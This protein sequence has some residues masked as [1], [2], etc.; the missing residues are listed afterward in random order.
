M[1]N[2]E[3]PQPI[4]DHRAPEPAPVAESNSSSTTVE[5]DN[6]EQALESHEVIELQTFS[7]RKAW[8]EEKIKF[9]ESLPPIEVFAD[10]D[11]L[12][13]SA[14]EIPGLPTR[15]QLQQWIVE[16]DLIEK[17]SEIFDKGELK[18]LRQLT[19]AATQRNLSPEDTDLIELTLTTIYALDKL[20]HLLR[21]RSDNLDL[22][23]IRLDWEEQRS[24]S[25]IERRR[26]LE[27]LDMFMTTRARW[28]P[29]IYDATP[30]VEDSPTLSR[31][32]SVT[33]M[34]SVTSDSSSMNNP[35]FARSARFK[36]GEL[37]G[38]DA[39]Q[40]GARVT[41]LSHGRVAAAGRFL[42]KLIDHSRKPVPEVLLDEQDRLEE[43]SINQMENVNKFVLSL[44]MQ[45]R[46]AD[47]IYVETVK[48]QIAAK[49]LLE[50]IQAARY[51][52]PTSRQS[53]AFKSRVDTLVQRLSVRVNPSTKITTFPKP[54]HHLF[55]QQREANDALALYLTQEIAAAT[56]LSQQAE[57]AAK[58]Y[59]DSWEAVDRVE[60]LVSSANELTSSFSSV[61]QRL[62]DGVSAESE[63]GSP[64]DLMSND[65]LEP[66]RH[67]VFLALLPSIQ[68]EASETAIKAG[69]LVKQSQLA[70]YAL[71]DESIDPAFKSD[72]KAAIRQLVA[73][74]DQCQQLLDATSQRVARL[75]EARHVWAAMDANLKEMQYVR[76]DIVQQ[77]EHDCWKQEAS[78]N[79]A[80]LTPESPIVELSPVT[81]SA[82]NLE[83]D[84]R[85]IGKKL[86]DTVDT[87][88]QALSVT[89]EKPLNECLSTK[90]KSVRMF[91]DGL[92]RMNAMLKTIQEQ[93]A[94]MSSVRSE[95]NAFLLRIEDAKARLGSLTENVLGNDDSISDV[96]AEEVSTNL[97]L[98]GVQS[99]V[100]QFI[101]SLASRV[102]FVSKH[103]PLSPARATTFRRPSQGKTDTE[104]EDPLQRLPLDLGKLDA[105]VRAD[106][107]TYVMR[108]RGVLDSVAKTSRQLDVAHLAKKVDG[109][110]QD[111]STI[112][113]QAEDDHDALQASL[114]SLPDAQN[115]KEGNLLQHIDGLTERVEAALN[116][117]RPRLSRC[118]S[119]IRDMLRQMDASA[120]DFEPS[121]RQTLYS[122]RLR[123]K[124][125]STLATK[126]ALEAEEQRK[127]EEEARRIAE[128]VERKR[129]EE[130]ARVRDEAR[131]KEEQRLE[132]VRQA[133]EEE[134]RKREEEAERVR[135]EKEKVEE[136]ERKRKEKA[137][138]DEAA[139]AQREK[140]RMAQ[141][142]SEKARLM[143]ERRDIE[144]KL[145]R[146]ESLLQEERRLQA[147]REQLALERTRI[148]KGQIKEESKKLLLAEQEA[149][150]HLARADAERVKA[151]EE[152]KRRLQKELEFVKGEHRRAL[153][154]REDLARQHQKAQHRSKPSVVEDD[155]FGLSTPATSATDDE[156]HLQSVIFG[157]R[158]RLRSLNINE[159]ARPM[160][161]KKG[162]A[163]LPS[164]DQ[165][166]M[167]VKEASQLPDS[168]PNLTVDAELR[169]FRM[170]LE[171]S[172]QLI[173]DIDNLARLSEAI[174]KCD[175]A[176]SDLLEHIDSYPSV[177]LTV[178][179][180]HTSNMSSLPS[181]QLAA[182]TAFTRTV[183]DEMQAIFNTV[184]I[185][186]RAISERTRVHQTW[187]ELEEMAH[188][189]LGGRKS[190][191][192]SV[193]S[194]HLSS[195]RNSSASSSNL[196]STPGT[197]PGMSTKKRTSYSNLSVSSINV[198]GGKL[199]PPAPIGNR[200]AV[201]GESRRS[202]S[203][204]SISSS[205]S[206]SGPGP[207]IPPVPFNSSVMAATF[208]SRQRTSSIT[209]VTGNQTPTAGRG[210]PV[211]KARVQSRQTRSPSVGAEPSSRSRSF[212]A[213]VPPRTTKT[214]G[215]TWSRAP[216]NSLSSMMPRSMTPQKPKP[217]GA[218]PR[219][220][221]IADPKS[222]L[223]VAVGDVV[224]QLPVGINVESVSETWRDQSG[225]YWIGN[226]DPKLCFCR[227]LRSQ[228][229]MVRVGGGWAELSKFIKD[230]FAESFRL[231]P[232]SP[233]RGSGGKQQEEKWISSATLLEQT[234]QTDSPQFP[235][236]PPP[237]TPEPTG[238][239]VP[240]FSLL[241]P[242]G[243]SP[244][245]I[246]SSPGTPGSNKGT[247]TASLTPMQFI[248]RADPTDPTLLR[249]ITPSKP[250]SLSRNPPV[251]PSRGAVWR[252]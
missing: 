90:A 70:F 25:W 235:P 115:S 60:T 128:E 178:S 216:R 204:M 163:G 180:L 76:D 19:K 120:H 197:R 210:T 168:V 238:P 55:P 1:P 41:N 162:S 127:R 102:P 126:R 224:N 104:V 241:T 69:E 87:P 107:N 244:R 34:A 30:K 144:A 181:E 134:R 39:A 4:Q 122:S 17:E 57:A 156:R 109:A 43:K 16:H 95:Y 221:Y 212:A 247:S 152:E 203:R 6:E 42:D 248:R 121:V 35:M 170:E 192:V 179:N 73:V 223:D 9:L 92:L 245:S 227:I 88:L 251:T 190:R 66:R 150:K 205:R 12:R 215:S 239:F 97:E 137:A 208:A 8:I 193:T 58:E 110:I 123:V 45:W 243:Q 236:P 48:D 219:K 7:E 201:S 64:P 118:L 94:T 13:E 81:P 196:V 167:L 29:S 20:L 234:E 47:E 86:V 21:D 188:D 140:D 89:L 209:S 65:C 23:G 105:A 75:R 61:I 18:K 242:S 71:S 138:R 199:A 233:P 229:V 5:E 32:A 184:S 158:K 31:R 28:S 169:S 172:E 26:I 217:G 135:L 68:S 117:S 114:D 155:V 246:L 142:A 185:D 164:T 186:T 46:K 112:I 207:S 44:I 145:H 33:S 176:L 195:G 99:E 177:P 226:Q 40:F 111:A 225:K 148:E 214:S 189:R 232:E 249:P 202:S 194:T 147:E 136:A 153:S 27:D 72:A 77:M 79:G 146:A 154:E 206:V 36:L 11:A 78:G 220:K 100:G 82:S 14:E 113:Q 22:L 116:D 74:Q 183:M 2:P 228:T 129:K 59:R 149:H 160:K 125:W 173:D 218:Q 3:A 200:R 231:M 143:D 191:P 159:L 62:T 119:P 124:A 171:S 53:S 63:D 84:L 54:E 132:E 165:F 157:L 67:S 24:A 50:D 91:H 103:A 252:P 49:D 133:E 141:N 237:K 198:Q 85:Q 187:L 240:S 38:R 213:P 139:R 166:T 161:G 151:A 10:L 37:L 15:E 51:Q 93:S 211:S 101:D 52:H 230:H 182:R 174:V 131:R 80:P 98:S 96:K 108:L 175:T 83:A 222:K 106:S 250:S 56:E 130:E